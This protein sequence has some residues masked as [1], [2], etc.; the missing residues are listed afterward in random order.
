MGYLKCKSCGGCYQL[1]PGESPGDFERCSC[2]GELEFY[3]DKGRRRGYKPIYSVKKGSKIHPIIKIL[4]V[5]VGG[6]LL[7]AYGGGLV[8][9][10]LLVGIE[11]F[12]PSGGTYLFAIFFGILIAIISGLLWFIFRKRRKNRANIGESGED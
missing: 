10:F 3:D 6:Y 11:Y 9:Y 2:G 4:I 8:I 12:G 5:I 7:F 1:Q